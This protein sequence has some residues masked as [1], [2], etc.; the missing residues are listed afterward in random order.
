M[1]PPRW[2]GLYSVVKAGAGAEEYMYVDL[3]RRRKKGQTSRCRCWTGGRSTR[4]SD[5][6]SKFHGTRIARDE[7]TEGPKSA[8]VGRG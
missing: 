2:M 5:G 6:N 3:I 4:S 8:M 7:H 1:A